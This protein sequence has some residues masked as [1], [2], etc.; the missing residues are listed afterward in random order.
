MNKMAKV[1]LLLAIR[2]FD[3][4]RGLKSLSKSSSKELNLE[5]VMPG[6]TNAKLGL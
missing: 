2:F 4:S 6:K 5:K 3:N 1:V